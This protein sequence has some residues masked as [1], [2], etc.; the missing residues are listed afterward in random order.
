MIDIAMICYTLR[1]M[2]QS[3]HAPVP[4][5]HT[6]RYPLRRARRHAGA[7][8]GAVREACKHAGTAD[9]SS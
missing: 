1:A 4:E 9:S 8:A 7:Q 2:R 3:R 5:S 6:P